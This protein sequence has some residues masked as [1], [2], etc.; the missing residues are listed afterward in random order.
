MTSEAM[1]GA[2]RRIKVCGVVL[3]VTLLAS[4]AA[5][6]PV[7]YA[8]G[9][10]ENHALNKQV[11][12]SSYTQIYRAE[13]ANDGNVFTYWEGAP[14]SYPNTLTLDLGDTCTVKSVVI[15]LNPD[16]IW[17]RRTQTLAVLASADGADFVTV[18]DAAEYTFDPETG[19]AVTINFAAVETRYLR[20]VFTENSGATGGQVAELEV[21]S[22]STEEDPLS[23]V[24]YPGPEGV[25][26]AA[27]REVFVNGKP[28]FVYDT[29][30]N[31]NRTWAT[32]PTLETTPV[33]YFDFGG[34]PVTITVKAPGTKIESAVIRPLSLGIVP[35]IKD[36]TITFTLDAPA[37]VTVEINGEIRRA[38][39]IFANPLESDPPTQ[40]DPGVIYFGPG[41]HNVGRINVGSGQ[42]VYIAGGAVVYGWIHPTGATNVRI[43]G[44]GILDGSVYDRWGDTVNPISLRYCTNAVVD[45]ICIFNP[46]AWT[47]EA[48][49]STNVWIN[50][51]KIISARANGDG[52]TVQSCVNFKAEDCFIRSWDDSLVVKGYDG[53]VRSVAFENI[54]IWTDL[55]Q[56]C[57]IGYECRAAVMEDIYF[58]NI[59]VLHNFHKPVLS[60][61]NSDTAVVRNVRYED[62]TV[63]DA[64]MGQGDGWNYFIDLWIGP[65]QWSKSGRERGWIENVYFKNV[66]V[67]GG[68]T[69]MSRICGWDE[70]HVIRGVH[71]EDVTILGVPVADIT[72]AGLVGNFAYVEDLTFEG[73]PADLDDAAQDSSSD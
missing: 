58:K 34:A 23:V 15:K 35:E 54:Q 72:S 73:V 46:A 6:A 1:S 14:R 8:G 53:D 48:Y 3:L 25:P 21:Y 28:L 27:D 19:N 20:L 5:L 65:S 9:P 39:H 33:A 69:P 30:V 36:E 63:E 70:A 38:L 13:N 18:V 68:R 47:L 44:R 26:A 4:M 55:A 61:H 43:T 66:K 59:T 42:T 40:G 7:G 31:L 37:K 16:P 52:I 49:K 45:G 56:S 62:I 50:N 51:V 41:V 57:E 22:E 11:T 17:A 2:P 60:I 10:R 67:L 71:L 24:I 29:A 32:R 64:Q 12:A